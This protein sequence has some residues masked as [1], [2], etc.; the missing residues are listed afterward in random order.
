MMKRLV[1]VATG[2]VLFAMLA[3]GAFAQAKPEVLVKQRQAVMT[4]QG[5][6][7][8]PMAAMAQGKAP[9]NAAVVQRNAGFLD[10]LSR[11]SWDGFDASTRG[12]KSR[13]LPAVFD[14][15]AAFKETAARLENEAAK[16]VAVSRS[17]DEA[18]VKAQIGAVGKTCGGCHDEFRQKQ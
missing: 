5:K 11:M 6:Y 16:L 7:F 8:G 13:A 14:N 17:G 10:N 15:S 2:A 3:P 9:F 18:A 4:L 12:E 1:T